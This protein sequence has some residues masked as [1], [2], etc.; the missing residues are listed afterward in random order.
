[1]PHGYI[2]L[3]ED[4]SFGFNWVHTSAIQSWFILK[5]PI[6][7]LFVDSTNVSLFKS[8]AK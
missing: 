1:M 5:S 4:F 3:M 8:D 7:G 6:G 2:S